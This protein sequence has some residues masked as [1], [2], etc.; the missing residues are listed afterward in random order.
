MRNEHDGGI[1]LILQ[2]LQQVKNLRL[3]GD[4]QC[5]R[6]LIRNNKS[7]RTGKRNGNADPLPHP[8]GQFMRIHVVNAFLVCNPNK[9]KHLKCSCF[10]SLVIHVREV[11]LRHF[12]HLGTDF[13]NGIQARHR[14][15]E[16]HGNFVP[17]NVLHHRVRCIGNVIGGSVPFVETNLP[18]DDLP[19]RAL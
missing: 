18:A 3:N 14:L 9:V 8:T 6:R 15:L 1:E 10:N 5:C 12:I 4:I 13:E 2:A 19:A 7:R 17:A 11:K 16:D